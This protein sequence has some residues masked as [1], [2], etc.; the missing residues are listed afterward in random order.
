MPLEISFQPNSQTSGS[1]SALASAYA[2]NHV[3][4]SFLLFCQKLCPAFLPLCF[5][6]L[7]HDYFLRLTL[8]PC[9]SL[10]QPTTPFLI[11]ASNSCSCLSVLCF[12][13]IFIFLMNPSLLPPVCSFSSGK[14]NL[15][16]TSWVISLL[17]DPVEPGSAVARSK[18]CSSEN[19][20]L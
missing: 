4:F 8:W 10:S 19:S 18:R 9:P 14:R 7:A 12:I 11:C 3:C 17:W 5:L 20:S 2:P 16:I 6:P 13:A 15:E 1:V